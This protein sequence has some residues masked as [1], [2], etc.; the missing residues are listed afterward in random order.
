MTAS[1][2]EKILK[3]LEKKPAKLQR[4]L[5]YNK[6]K[7]RKFGEDTRKCRRCGRRGAH[8]R[9]YGLDVCRQCFREIAKELGFKKYGHEV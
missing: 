3:Q 7:N 5:K 8:I 2:Y 1:S 9:K 4:F 6:P